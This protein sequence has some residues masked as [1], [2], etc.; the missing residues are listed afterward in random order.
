MNGE[1]SLTDV[2]GDIVNYLEIDDDSKAR[3]IFEFAAD[4]CRDKSTEFGWAKVQTD[5]DCSSN[6]IGFGV[7][8]ESGTT[9]NTTLFNNKYKILSV[10]HNHPDGSMSPSRSDINHAKDVQEVFPH[11]TFSIYRNDGT[12]LPYEGNTPVIE[13]SMKTVKISANKQPKTK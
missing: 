4:N 5:I 6:L 1:K 10:T 3:E 13:R 8:N 11:A 9:A 7:N 2:N 12:Y